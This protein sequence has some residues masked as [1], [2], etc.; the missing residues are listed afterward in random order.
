MGEEG[1]SYFCFFKIGS[2]AE[3][4]T[5][6]GLL[7]LTLTLLWVTIRNFLRV[8]HLHNPAVILIY[9]LVFGWWISRNPIIK[10]MLSPIYLG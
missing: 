8:R 10:L 7:A 2:E 1:Q 3:L 4:G 5:M 9:R 6:I